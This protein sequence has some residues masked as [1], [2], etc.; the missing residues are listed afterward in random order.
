MKLLTTKKRTIRITGRLIFPIEIGLP[1]WIQE[2]GGMRR[3][4]PVLSIVKK[5]AK[6]ILIET[7]NTLYILKREA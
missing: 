3:T 7:Q 5:D 2:F 6:H 4:S 1:A